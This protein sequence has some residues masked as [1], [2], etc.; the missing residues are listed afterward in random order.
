MKMT[1]AFR[2]DG[3]GFLVVVLSMAVMPGILEEI[4]FRGVMQGYLMKH[5]KPWNAVLV[6][7]IA[8]GIIHLQFLNF[9]LFFM[10][11]Y[12]SW[13]RWKSGSIYPCIL[14]HF[15]H[16]FLVVFFEWYT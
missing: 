16:N 6:T 4:A 10:G 9:P 15:G 2:E 12:F 11:I 8:F 13:L 14:A 5:M 7:G 3:Y 1:T